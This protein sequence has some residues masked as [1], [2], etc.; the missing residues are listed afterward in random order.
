VS[1]SWDRKNCDRIERCTTV[2]ENL[3]IYCSEWT[4]GYIQLIQEDWIYTAL[5]RRWD[6]YSGEREV[7]YIQQ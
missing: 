7:G 5:G 2:S 4:V 3:D 6:I 1:G